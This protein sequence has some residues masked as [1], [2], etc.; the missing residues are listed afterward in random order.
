[1]DKAL[2]LILILVSGVKADEYASAVQSFISG[3]VFWMKFK[4]SLDG[5]RLMSGKD[6]EP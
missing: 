1:M 6:T 2:H 3:E 5:K 4:I